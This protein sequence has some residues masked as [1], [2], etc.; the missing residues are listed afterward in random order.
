MYGDRYWDRS[1]SEAVAGEWSRVERE[2]RHAFSLES[3]VLVPAFAG[4]GAAGP[5]GLVVMVAAWRFTG[6]VMLWAGLLAVGVVWFLVSFYVL[7]LSLSGFK[8][9]DQYSGASSSSEE[10][11]QQRQTLRL[12]VV[13][14]KAGNLMF[15]EDLPVDQERFMQW[16][17]AV[18]RGRDLSGSTW[19]GPGLLFSRP[20]YEELIEYLIRAGLVRWV[21]ERAHTQ[22]KEL[23]PAGAATLK[24]AVER[25]EYVLEG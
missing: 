9:L 20:E 10:Q 4:V 6:H 7:E 14:P 3:N 22:G 15:S 25:S 24:R 16:A 19:G 1:R 2:E 17:R 12:E 18:V 21:N 5:A 11:Q 13:N 23:S 8:R